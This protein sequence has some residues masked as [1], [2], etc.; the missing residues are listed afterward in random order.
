MRM[1]PILAT[2]PIRRFINGPKSFT[3]DGLPLIGAV[4][5]VDGLIVATAMNSAGV[6]W[7]AMAG[8]IV[9][10]LVTG[11]TQRFSF[12]QYA[13]DRFGARASDTAWLRQQVSGIVS[14]GYRGDKT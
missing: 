10:R 3:P 7:S 9:F 12:A 5:G 4:D 14:G 6:T 8:D 13:P 11:E 1:F 2:A